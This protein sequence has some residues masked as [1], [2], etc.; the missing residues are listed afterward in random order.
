MYSTNN[1]FNSVIAKNKKDFS[2]Y[3]GFNAAKLKKK[4]VDPDSHLK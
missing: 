2:K 3:V 4:F 1:R